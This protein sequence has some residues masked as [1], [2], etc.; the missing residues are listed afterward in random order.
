MSAAPAKPA[1]AAS[2]DEI[3]HRKALRPGKWVALR[4]PKDLTAE[5]ADSLCEWIRAL[6]PPAVSVVDTQK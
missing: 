6:G 3:T 4:L 5:E 1:R 2:S